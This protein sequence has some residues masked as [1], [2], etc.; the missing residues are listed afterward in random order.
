MKLKSAEGIVRYVQNG[1]ETASFYDTIGFQVKTREPHQASAYLDWFWID[2][3]SKR[4]QLGRKKRP[5][6]G[7]PIGPY[8]WKTGQKSSETEVK[9]SSS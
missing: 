3:L 1:D 7:M 8:S 6:G 9:G 5:L 4:D 2:F